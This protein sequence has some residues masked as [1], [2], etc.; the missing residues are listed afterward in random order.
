MGGGSDQLGTS[1]T[2]STRVPTS[3]KKQLSKVSGAGGSVEGAA[4]S[5]ALRRAS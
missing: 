2:V 1:E 5:K 3:V 4:A